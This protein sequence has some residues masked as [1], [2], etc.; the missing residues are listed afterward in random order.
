MLNK[1]PERTVPPSTQDRLDLVIDL[2]DQAQKLVRE[3]DTSTRGAFIKIT[4]AIELIVQVIVDEC[5]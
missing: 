4:R 2:I 3:S 5:K 1:Y